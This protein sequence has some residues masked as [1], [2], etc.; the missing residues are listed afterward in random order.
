MNDT[1]KACG[2]DLSE[3]GGYCLNFCWEDESLPQ[4]RADAIYAEHVASGGSDFNRTSVDKLITIDENAAVKSRWA[5]MDGATNWRDA[6]YTFMTFE[7]LPPYAQVRQP[8]IRK[9]LAEAKERG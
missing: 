6:F 3:A 5:R 9:A 8:Q 2:G 7:K 1:C 4:A